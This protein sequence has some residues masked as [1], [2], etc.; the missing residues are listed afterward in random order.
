MD[1]RV[2]PLREDESEVERL[3]EELWLPF[4]REMADVDDYN[5]LVDEGTAREH[6]LS[7]RHEQLRD[8]DCRVWIAVQEGWL[9]YVRASVSSPPPVFDRGR[10]LR[11][12]ELYVVPEARGEGVADALLDRA[13]EWGEERDCERV[14]L[15]VNAENDRARSFYERRGFEAR[16]LKLDRSL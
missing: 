9:G 7:Y 11:I 2:R 10:T 3:V 15:S 14:G 13:T 4:A 8:E 5:E 12:G 1:A 6:G 16:R